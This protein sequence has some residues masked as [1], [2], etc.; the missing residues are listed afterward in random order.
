MYGHGIDEIVVA[1]VSEVLRLS[2]EST[3]HA[4]PA[5]VRVR[6]R[7]GGPVVISVGAER[8]KVAVESCRPKESVGANTV[9]ATRWQRSQRLR[10]ELVGYIEIVAR[11]CRSSPHRVEHE[12]ATGEDRC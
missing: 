2:A 6:T 3:L 1:M 7:A 4:G 5:G 11:C 12:L 8:T 10:N 9:I